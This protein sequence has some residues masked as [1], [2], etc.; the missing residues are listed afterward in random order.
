M[1]Q[2]ANQ[3]I[4][5]F[6]NP[7]LEKMTHV[8]PIIPI[9]LWAP[10]ISYFLI[11][12]FWVDEVPKSTLFLLGVSGVLTWTLC[13]YLLHRFLFHWE[14]KAPFFKRLVYLFHGIHHDSPQDST[15][16]LMPPVPAII[17]ASCFAFVFWGI[18][19]PIWG[20][21][22]FAFFMI[23]Y[24]AYDYTHYALHHVQPRTLL[25]K[26]MKLYHMQHHFQD[27]HSKFGVTTPLWDHCFG[28]VSAQ[29]EPPAHNNL[30]KNQTA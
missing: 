2:K 3:S 17:F 4:Q 27:T 19:G 21:P 14:T 22:F 30:H 11:S 26:A 29:L 7:W 13:E 24:L 23:G 6:N 25:G 1:M 9:L 16:L 28:S 12:A 15:R 5:L 18:L 20:P 8:H 10:I